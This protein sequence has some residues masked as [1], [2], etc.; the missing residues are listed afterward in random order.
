MKTTLELDPKMVEEVVKLGEFANEQQAVIAALVEF[1]EK[2]QR[3]QMLELAGQ[4]DFDPAWDYK[5][6]RQG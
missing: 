3:M 1:I 5:K 2:R 4:I 6:M